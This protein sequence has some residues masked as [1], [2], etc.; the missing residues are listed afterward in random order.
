MRVRTIQVSP[1]ATPGVFSTPGQVLLM[2][3]IWFDFIMRGKRFH[4]AVPD[5]Y[6]GKR[7]D[8]AKDSVT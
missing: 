5:F 8:P 7:R 4:P 2:S 6:H 1:P 3:F